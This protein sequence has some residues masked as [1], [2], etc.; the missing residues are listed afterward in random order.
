MKKTMKKALSL[1]LAALLC[2]ALMPGL[3]ASAAGDA[4]SL[5]QVRELMNAEPL[6]PQKTGYIELDQMLEELVAPYEGQDT[7]TTL[8][9]LY[10]WTVNNI[11]Y[12]WKGYS[13]DYAPAYDCFTLTYDLTYETGLPQAYPV[14]M[15]YR[16]YHMLTARTGVCYDWGIL[17]AVMARY[18]GVESYVHT[19]ILR[20]GTWTGHHG[21]TELKLGGRNYI[22]DGQQDWRSKGIYGRI[23]YDHFGIS[24]ENASRYRQETDANA[25]RDA[26]MLPVTDP[27]VRIA[28]VTVVPSR[29]GQVEGGGVC[30]WGEETVLT[31]AGELPVVGWYSPNG[32]LLSSEESYTIT[33]TADTTIYALFEGDVFVDLP[34]NAWY[35]EDVLQAH[36]LELVS[37]MSEAF[38]QPSGTMNRAQF[39]TLL[40][41]VEGGEATAPPAPFEDVSQAQWY[42]NAI[43]WAYASGVVHGISDTQFQPLGSVTR[44]QAATMMVQYLENRGVTSSAQDP[45]FVDADQISPYAWEFLAQAQDLGLLSGYNDGTVQPGK[46]LSRAEGVALLMNLIDCLAAA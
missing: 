25:A 18:V 4:M 21:W 3:G 34:A 23:V 7:Y 26:S 38:F 35:L 10:E 20:I 17:F 28:N 12:S 1:L 40:Y 42:A 43:N 6:Y 9:G 19:G 45:D 44:E 29:S 5:D 16:A 11:D 2:A 15:I 13:Q 24:M 37:G 27:R 31:S 32:A 39:A 41:Q 22:F 30:V 33:P 8:K 36:E 14:D 46:I